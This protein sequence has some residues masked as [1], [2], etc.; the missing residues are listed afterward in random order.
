MEKI[1]RVKILTEINLLADYAIVHG[2]AAAF[3]ELEKIANF[4]KKDFKVR[5][6][7]LAKKMQIKEF[8]KKTGHPL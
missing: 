7:A 1:D 8:Y 6:A 5:S 2:D 3:D 4:S